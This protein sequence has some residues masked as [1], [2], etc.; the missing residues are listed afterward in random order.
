MQ[1]MGYFL[2]TK[3]VKEAYEALTSYEPVSPGILHIFLI[4]KGAGYNSITFENL[5]KLGREALQP[6]YRISGLFSPI[7]HSPEAYNF[8][9]PFQMKSWAAQAPSEN[10]NKWVAQRIKNNILGGA[11]TWRPIITDDPDGLTIKFKHDYINVISDEHLGGKKIPF[12]AI[13]IWANRFN[14]FSQK[15]SSSQLVSIFMEDFN[16][17]KK[18]AFALFSIKNNIQLSFDEKIHDASAI[19]KII[20]AP[21]KVDSNKWVASIQSNNSFLINSSIDRSKFFKHISEVK[22]MDIEKIYKLLLDNHQI[23]LSGPPGTSKSFFAN[24][25][26]KE[27]FDNNFTKVQ[28]HPKYSYN[29]FIGGYVVR[30]TNVTYENGILID[31]IQNKLK[32]NQKYLL[33]I[34]EINRAN[35]GQVFGET[36]QLLDRDNKIQIRL[37]GDLKEFFLPDNLYIVGT[38]NSSDRSLGSLDFAIRRRFSFVYCP[39]DP[40]LLSDLCKADFD[41]SIPDFLR[42]LNQRLYEV[43]KN[44]ELAIGHTLFLKTDKENTEKII[45]SLE[46]FTDLFN[47]KILPM[48]EEYC[49]GNI[50]QLFSILGS[51]LPKRLDGKEFIEAANNFIN[52]N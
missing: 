37:D 5:S 11:T 42:K 13:A 6:A 12:E 51:E 14:E 23:I 28:F 24:K 33:I 39:P 10:L 52:A 9:S 30:G 49:H 3:T 22:K 17:T 19:R 2:A 4:L 45:W 25:L 18:E 15:I 27:Y 29:D 31:I 47:H 40:L 36:I 16:I 34:D 35:V 50:N 26:A 43:L 32:T 38:M 41:L 48:I 21:N 1:I 20:G 44:P 7:E 8:I 46:N